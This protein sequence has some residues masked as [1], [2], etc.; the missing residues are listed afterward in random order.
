MYTVKDM[1]K[2]NPVLELYAGTSSDIKSLLDT[3]KSAASNGTEWNMT[4]EAYSDTI[5][6]LVDGINQ[7]LEAQ[8]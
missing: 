6:T 2:E 5:D 3:A 7:Q 8:S 4:V 1:T